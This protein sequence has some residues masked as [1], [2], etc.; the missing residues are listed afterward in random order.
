MYSAMLSGMETTA[1]TTTSRT[2]QAPRDADKSHASHAACCAPDGL[3]LP[4]EPIV[5]ASLE[6][7]SERLKALA[8]SSRLRMLALLS[9]QAAPLCVCEINAYFAQRQ[10]TISH[11]LK[12]LREAGLIVGEKRGTWSYYSITAEGKRLLSAVLAEA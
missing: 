9:D 4:A 2:T 11:H 6:Q 7:L 8:D 12:L 3:P 1:N 5:G 10:P